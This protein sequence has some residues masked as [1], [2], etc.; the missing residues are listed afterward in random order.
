[1]IMKTS[2][3]VLH[4]VEEAVANLKKATKPYLGEFPLPEVL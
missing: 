2:I 3:A 1:M 4:T